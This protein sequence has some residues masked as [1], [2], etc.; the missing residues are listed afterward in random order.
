MENEM[1]DTFYE[2]INDLDEEI[3]PKMKD[4]VD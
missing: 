3:I 1:I 4:I 2:K